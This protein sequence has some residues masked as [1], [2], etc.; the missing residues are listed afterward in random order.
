M[1]LYR[2]NEH[3]KSVARMRCNK[4]YELQ[5]SALQYC[6][7]GKWSGTEPKCKRKEHN[8]VYMPSISR[9]PAWKALPIESIYASFEIV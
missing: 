6:S 5:G 1:E 7:D 9:D 3:G 2:S 8:Y 4:G